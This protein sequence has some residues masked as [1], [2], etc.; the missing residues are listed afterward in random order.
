MVGRRYSGAEKGGTNGMCLPVR[1]RR[2][3]RLLGVLLVFPSD[4][5]NRLCLTLSCR[6]A[7]GSLSPS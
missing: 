5:N 6:K 3:Y 2:W 4:L 7:E 1:K